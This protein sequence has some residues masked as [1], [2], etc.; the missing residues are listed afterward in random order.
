[1][2]VKNIFVKNMVVKIMADFSKT[3]QIFTTKLI[4][5]FFQP[6]YFNKNCFQFSQITNKTPN[7]V[8]YIDNKPMHAIQKGVVTSKKYL[9]I[10]SLDK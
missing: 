9:I 6:S 1:M 2:V 5:R 8:N 3:R 10:I 4:Q 7:C